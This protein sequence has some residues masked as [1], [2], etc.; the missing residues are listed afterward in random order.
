MRGQRALDET[1]AALHERHAVV[2]EDLGDLVLGGLERVL[3]HVFELGVALAHAGRE[4]ELERDEVLPQVHRLDDDRLALHG[5][6]PPGEW[7]PDGRDVELAVG[8]LLHLPPRLIGRIEVGVV[9]E[10]VQD[11]V[12]RQPALG[13]H[14]ARARCLEHADLEVLQRGIV[15]AL[16]VEAAVISVGE[17]VGRPVDGER[18]QRRAVVGGQ[19]E[20]HVAHVGVERLAREPA[21]QVG[22]PEID[23]IGA[24]RVRQHLGD[25]VLESV[26]VDVRQRHIAGVGADVELAERLLLKSLLRGGFGSGLLRRRE[27]VE[28]LLQIAGGVCRRGKCRAQSHTQAETEQQRDSCALHITDFLYFRWTVVRA[29]VRRCERDR[30][31][32]AMAPAAARAVDAIAYGLSVTPSPGR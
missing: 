16:E 19:V 4:L 27:L 2:G 26:P 11:E 23:E 9:A 10:R 6:K 12:G 15:E 24:E 18:R 32:A 14:L 5:L 22:A 1:A 28:F 8:H 7:A 13:Q 17:D 25:L 29:R 30:R 31:N 21:L 20:E 3:E